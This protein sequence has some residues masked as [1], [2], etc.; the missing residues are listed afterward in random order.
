MP[1]VAAGAALLGGGIT[2]Y[3]QFSQGQ[4]AKKMYNQQASVAEMEANQIRQAGVR[5]ADIIGKNQVLNEFRQ[6]KQ[7]DKDT[8]TMTAGYAKRGVAS[9]GS[10]LDA[11]AD[12][13]SNAELEID[14]GKWNAKVN[15][16]TTLYN[17]RMASANKMSQAKLQREYGKS[18]ANNAMW[19]AGGTLLSSIGTAAYR[20]QNEI[21]PLKTKIGD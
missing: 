6:R 1:M 19:Q 4:E 16:D 12:S 10:P 21:V 11:I 7:L 9:T 2:A 14:I 17:T 3:G 18:A 13:I 8:G 20:K 5:E 15:Q